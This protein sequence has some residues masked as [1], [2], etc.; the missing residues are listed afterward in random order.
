MRSTRRSNE[1][2]GQAPGLA[3]RTRPPAAPFAALLAAGLLA[4]PP[5][6][7]AAP[8]ALELG[9]AWGGLARPGGSTELRIRLS[10]ARAGRARLRITSGGV[11]IETALALRAA[12]AAQLAIPLPVADSFA[13][14]AALPGGSRLHRDL[15]LR[16]TEEPLIALSPG[17]SGELP[18]GLAHADTD[19]SGYPSHAEAYEAVDAVAIDATTLAQLTPQQ[20]QA[21]LTYVERCGPTL[22]VGLPAPAAALLRANAGCQGA[23]LELLANP[24][25][26]GPAAAALL[27]SAP[28]TAVSAASLRSLLAGASR[29]W[30]LLVAGL[31]LY[32]VGALLLAAFDA[33]TAVLATYALAAA[34][35]AWVA[36]HFAAATPRLAVWAESEAG[37][38]WGRYA[39]LGEFPGG[40]RARRTV[41]LPRLLEGA[42]TCPLADATDTAAPEPP[43]LW[44]WNSQSGRFTAVTLQQR[45]FAAPSICWHG[46]FPLARPAA[47]SRG[48]DGKPSV[49]NLGDGPWPAGLAVLD[50]VSYTLPAAAPRATVALTALPEDQMAA[51]AAQLALLRASGGGALLWPLELPSLGLRQASIRAYLLE[52]LPGAEDAR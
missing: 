5:A 13:V 51:P 27:A 38:H 6:V 37:A 46:A 10:A 19:A 24:T 23:A 49:T 32:A 29:A 17:A 36:G 15:T 52:R 42:R 48:S 47:L 22:A 14:D 3:R 44:R 30:P 41:A 7:S 1:A 28:P 4:A 16:L 18:D 12:T 39:A 20:V 11:V 25:A 26:L 40:G 9:A 43:P 31:G 2:G 34:L 33:R 45:L 21:L 8:A 50:D 35:F